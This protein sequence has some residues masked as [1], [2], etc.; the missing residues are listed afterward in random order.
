MPSYKM[1][2]IGD[3]IHP[4]SS[5]SVQSTRGLQCLYCPITETLR[6]RQRRLVNADKEGC[7]V[8]DRFPIVSQRD[9]T[10]H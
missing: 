7:V 5:Y 6:L 1:L 3:R 9:V 10:F 2:D 8:R 4:Y